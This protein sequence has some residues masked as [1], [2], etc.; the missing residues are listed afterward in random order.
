LPWS[1]GH[2]RV[3]PPSSE[4]KRTGSSLVPRLDGRSNA[5]QLFRSE[6]LFSFVNGFFEPAAT[7][8][9][10]RFRWA[11]KSLDRIESSNRDKTDAGQCRLRG[12]NVRLCPRLWRHKPRN[13]NVVARR[14][15]GESGG[16][17]LLRLSSWRAAVA[18]RRCREF[19]GARADWRPR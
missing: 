15:L 6:T 3:S 8:G 11:R 16:R 9:V 17:L 1:A 7:P 10:V 12:A 18:A 4:G 14:I 19:R 2:H 5:E 13:R